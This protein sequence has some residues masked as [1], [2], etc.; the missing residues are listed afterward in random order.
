MADT[1]KD[2]Q[3]RVVVKQPD[4]LAEA[5]RRMLGTNGRGGRQRAAAIDQ[6]V[7]DD[8]TGMHDR[9]HTDKANQD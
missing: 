1:Y 7:T 8:V 5:W 3:G 2:A 4:S 9:Q 6:A